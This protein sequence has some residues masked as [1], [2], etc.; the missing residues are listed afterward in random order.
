M[1]SADDEIFISKGRKPCPQLFQRLMITYDGRVGMCCHDW[2]AQHCIGYLD[3][4]AFN[5]DKEIEEIVKCG[6]QILPTNGNP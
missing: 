1:I 6:I 2:G 3:S 5:E 4:K